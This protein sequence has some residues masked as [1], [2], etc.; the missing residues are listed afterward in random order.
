MTEYTYDLV[1]RRGRLVGFET[2]DSEAA[3]ARQK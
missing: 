3:S 2:E 1:L